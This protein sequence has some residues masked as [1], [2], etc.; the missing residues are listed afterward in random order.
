MHLNVQRIDI[1]VHLFVSLPYLTFT[2]C[3]TDNKLFLSSAKL[4]QSMLS[5]PI[6]NIHYN[7]SLP[8]TPTSSK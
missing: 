2:L 6:F 5:H 1:Y 7:G 8:S 4:T 3:I